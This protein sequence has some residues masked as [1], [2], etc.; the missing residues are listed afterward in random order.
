MIIDLHSH[1][2]ASDGV[3]SPEALIHAATDA[4]VDVLAVTDHDTVDGLTRAHQTTRPE[5]LII[6][7]G[8]EISCFFGN[9]EL[10]VL[11]LGIEATASGLT[12]WL[13]TLMTRRI[14]RMRGMVER[15]EEMG[16]ELDA[17]A[18]LASAGSGSVG[19][20]HIARALV[21]SGQV[22]SFEQAFNRYLNRG[23]PA[24][25]ERFK[26]G[27]TEAIERIH[28][29]G[30]VAVQ[31]HPGAMG[32]DEDIPALVE[33]GLD[34]LEV[35]HPEHGPQLRAR[36]NA[37]AEEMNLLV[38]GGSDFHGDSAGRATHLGQCTTDPAQFD[39]L[40][41]MREDYR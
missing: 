5:G 28:T 33:I 18:I 17:D 22:D 25:V 11:G 38:T 3:L 30:G 39:R 32:N 34:G 24:Y 40:V 31:A 29:A 1:T 6:L 35:N 4:G 37:M 8:I 12:T 13:R 14:E 36:Y 21:A 41:E 16:F 9:T 23:Q 15:L 10:H 7:G 26:L 27:V 2:T 20:P 19:R